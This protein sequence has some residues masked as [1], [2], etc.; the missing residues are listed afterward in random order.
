MR[1]KAGRRDVRR[2]EAVFR[3]AC[4]GNDLAAC[5]ELGALFLEELPRDDDASVALQR[6]ACDAGYLPACGHLAALFLTDGAMRIRV[7]KEADVQAA[8]SLAQK[9]CEGGYARACT[10]LGNVHRKGKV[11][12]RNH[13][14][15]KQMLERGCDGGDRRGCAIAS[16]L[17]ENGWDGEQP[18]KERAATLSR[19]AFELLQKDC[20]E[21]LDSCSTLAAWHAK[22][23]GTAVDPEKQRLV[24]RDACD[25]GDSASCVELG[26]LLEQDK[27]KDIDGAVALY[28]RACD[29]GY[30]SGCG[31]LGNM[32]YRG[33]GVP[34]DDK[35]YDELL[36][37]ACDLGHAQSCSWLGT[38]F[39][40]GMG[41][42]KDPAKAMALYRRACGLGSPM[43]CR[44]VGEAL[45]GT[46]THGIPS[47]EAHAEALRLLVFSCDEGDH[48]ACFYAAWVHDLGVGVPKNHGKA[49][50]FAK[51]ACAL[52]S[53]P[54][55][56]WLKAPDRAWRPEWIDFVKPTKK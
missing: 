20:A 38:R 35:R 47:K 49:E 31:K 8:V 41:T 10:V 14:L 56:V 39:A 46:D 22:G 17:Y 19:K 52:G 43:G 45:L 36:H 9:A 2:A 25:R 33:L 23:F 13:A 34:R 44:D 28:R 7:E 54:A 5:H 4:D 48:F 27:R 26:A 21:E 40:D 15:A 29:D 53:G 42:T 6:K 16:I 24:L 50:D 12:P 1:G 55:C 11:L 32:H 18:D 30:G 37:R 3:K 51:T